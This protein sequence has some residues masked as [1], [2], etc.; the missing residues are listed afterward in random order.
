MGD[1]RGLALATADAIHALLRDPGLAPA[2]DGASALPRFLV[3]GLAGHLGAQVFNIERVLAEPPG[4]GEVLAVETHYA[5]AAWIGADLD[6]PVNVSVRDEGER[7]AAGGQA[8]LAADVGA[9]VQR[10]RAALPAEPDDRVVLIPWSGR[11][12]RLDDFLV[13]RLLEMVVHADDLAASAPVAAPELPGAATDL[14]LGLLTRLA[15]RRHGHAAVLRAL[16]R[17]ERAAGPITAI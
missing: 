1:V 8:A 16:A 9:A 6:D 4:A 14:V 2:W 12:L 11:R 17:P 13:T 10:L 5:R 3:R 15:A 7:L